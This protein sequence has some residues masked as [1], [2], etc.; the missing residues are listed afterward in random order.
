MRNLI[1]VFLFVFLLGCSSNPSEKEI[2][3]SIYDYYN[4]EP[5]PSALLKYTLNNT[6]P[7]ADKNRLT[8]NIDSAISTGKDRSHEEMQI[9][10]IIWDD[11]KLKKQFK[12]IEDNNSKE[13][14]ECGGSVQC[15]KLTT[16]ISL[17]E[18][19]QYNN[20]LLSENADK[21]TDLY[22][23]GCSQKTRDY[24]KTKILKQLKETTLYSGELL[25]ESIKIKIVKSSNGWVI[26][27]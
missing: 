24:F 17:N 21:I 19:N 18:L 3:K 2:T 4:I 5:C 12:I 14:K 9:R 20:S 26:D 16:Q 11:E 27:R 10:N 13:L 7:G 6:I 8:L 22:L 23:G 1:P 25:K 15:I